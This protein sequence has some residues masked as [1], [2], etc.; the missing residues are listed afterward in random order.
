[1]FG[2]ALHLSNRLRITSF[3]FRWREF[4]LFNAG[5]YHSVTQVTRVVDALTPFVSIIFF[6]LS[7]TIFFFL[8]LWELCSRSFDGH[9]GLKPVPG[10]SLSNGESSAAAAR[11]SPRNTHYTSS[12]GSSSFRWNVSPHAHRPIYKRTARKGLAFFVV[13]VLKVHATLFFAIAN[14]MF[15]LLCGIIVEEAYSCQMPI[16]QII[17]SSAP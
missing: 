12:A 1:M 17:Q 5:N 6:L 14:D 16:I 9:S 15:T 7:T 13:K 2:L 11:R 10:I 8:L 4:A 3:R